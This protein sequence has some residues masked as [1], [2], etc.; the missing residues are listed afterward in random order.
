MTPKP[1]R[2]IRYNTAAIREA[3][4]GAESPCRAI[5]DARDRGG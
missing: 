4:R 5:G 3:G 2:V 1:W